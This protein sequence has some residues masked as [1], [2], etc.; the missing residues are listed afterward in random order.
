MVGFYYIRY[1]HNGT[2]IV[3][4][5]G[6]HGASPDTAQTKA[7]ELLGVVAGGNDPFAHA[8]ARE[9]FTTAIGVTTSIAGFSPVVGG[10]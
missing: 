2:Q 9:G 4:S 10:D 7:Q 3:K 8:L 6:R 1:R 5:I